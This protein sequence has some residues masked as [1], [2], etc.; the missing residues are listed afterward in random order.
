MVLVLLG[1]LSRSADD[2]IDKPGQI[3]SSGLSSSLP[4]SILDLV[5]EAAKIWEK[6]F[7][8]PKLFNLRAD[9]FERGDSSFL[10]DKWKFDRLFIFAPAQALVAQWLRSFKEFPLRQTPAAFN[11]DDVMAK[12][13]E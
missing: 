3:N 5:D 2:L 7:G 1:E 10:Y 6:E 8:V 12:L 4:A 11:L 13:T 9:P